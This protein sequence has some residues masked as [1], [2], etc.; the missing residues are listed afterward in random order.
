MRALRVVRAASLTGILA[1]LWSGW[2]AAST[3]GSGWS[4]QRTPNAEGAPNSSLYAV[5]CASPRSCMAVGESDHYGFPERP[6][7]QVLAERWNGRRWTI[8]PAPKLVVAG[9]SL[10]TGVSCASARSCTAVGSAGD[11]TLAEAWNGNKWTIQQTP[12]PSHLPPGQGLR[13][14]S[15][16]TARVCIAV[17]DY[18]PYI[19]GR[20]SNETAL[21]ERWNGRRWRILHVPGLAPPASSSLMGV[22]CPSVSDCT[23]VGSSSGRGMLAAHWD[24]RKWAIHSLPRLRERRRSGVVTAISCASTNACIAVGEAMFNP[25]YNGF[26]NSVIVAERWDGTKW[27]IQHPPSPDKRSYSTGVSC[28]SASTCT[29]L[30]SANSNR[31]LAERWNGTRW[32]M[33]RAP[34]P[35]T[36]HAVSGGLQGVSCPTDTQCTSVGSYVNE[37]RGMTS[38]QRTLAERW[39][40]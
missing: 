9:G 27:R 32:T 40:G 5:S 1:L 38:G 15:C 31:P 26:A 39:N 22:S 17:G 16:A 24:G 12:T 25:T 2:A 14:V 29:A 8:Q 20:S 33:Q 11:H 34:L 23:A 4:P 30:V 28:S 35:A 19:P 21:V 10:L 18:I 3:A 36:G 13:A 6:P 7:E 37:M